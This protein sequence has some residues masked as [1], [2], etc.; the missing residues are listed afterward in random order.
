MMR[1][2]TTCYLDGNRLLFG[3]LRYG[4][5]VEKMDVVYMD[6]METKPY[7]SLLNINLSNMLINVKC[8]KFREIA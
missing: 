6:I 7:F 4:A 3:H 8:K 1:H 2:R 5:Q